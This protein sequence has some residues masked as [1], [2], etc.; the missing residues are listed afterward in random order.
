M[1]YTLS[2]AH[3]IVGVASE[4]KTTFFMGRVS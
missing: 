1:E 3:V 4:S 2:V